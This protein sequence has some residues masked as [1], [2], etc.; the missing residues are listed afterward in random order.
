M[1]LL[2]I[3]ASFV[4]AF[5]LLADAECQKGGGLSDPLRV[6]VSDIDVWRTVKA[7]ARVR[8]G[9]GIGAAITGANSPASF[10][11]MPSAG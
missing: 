7:A 3:R 6:Y 5:S 10:V 1:S 4:S 9:A 2:N 8:S 11:A